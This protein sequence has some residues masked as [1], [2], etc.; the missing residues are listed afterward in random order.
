MAVIYRNLIIGPKHPL[1]FTARKL[2]G[3][4]SAVALLDLAG[5]DKR[6]CLTKG[7]AVRTDTFASK[8]KALS[9][10][11]QFHA[12]AMVLAG[13]RAAIEGCSAFITDQLVEKVGTFPAACHVLPAVSS[14]FSKSTQSLQP[15]LAR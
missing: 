12:P 6:L 4:V 8:I 3:T 2:N 11:W 7:H 14:F 1:G 10:I 9:H 15:A 13:R 5:F